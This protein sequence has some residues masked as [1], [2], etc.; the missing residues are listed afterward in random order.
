MRQYLFTILLTAALTTALAWMVWR[1]SMRYKLYPGIRERDVH[2]TP[3]PRLGG[4][5]MFLGIVAAILVSG[6]NPFFQIFWVDPRPVWAVLGAAVLIVLVGVA[7]DLWDLDWT[8]KLGAQFLAAGIIAVGGGLQVYTLPFG[9]M[10]LV[11]SW[12]SIT[13]TMFSIVIVMNAVNFIDGLDALVAGVCLIANG[14]FF[15]Y[16]YILS[17]DTLTTNSTLATFLAA[18]MIG[19]CAGF[20]PLNW[21][22]AKMFMGDSGALLLGLLMA[23]SAI[24]ASGQIPPSV[25]DPVDGLGRS[26]LLGAFLPILVPIVV[27]LLPLVDFGLAVIR[28]MGA[29][30]SPFS[31]DRK[32]LHHRMLDLGHSD[33]DAVLIFYAWTAV[34]SLAVLIM[35]LATRENWPG[36][37]WLGVIFGVVGIAA[38]L[39]LTLM[40]TRRPPHAPTD[41]TPATQEA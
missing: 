28:R 41:P 6:S 19:A 29:G 5:A 33:R 18:A 35:Y 13:L 9:G 16:S 4:V 34:I 27:V 36:E 10:T 37:Y 2:K 22:P 17:R 39:V 26:Q 7:D 21:R 31:P 12:V 24:A 23:T 15:V 25:L 8:I 20:L 30:K 40:P 14:V 11:S 3:T 38:C 1:L 32:H